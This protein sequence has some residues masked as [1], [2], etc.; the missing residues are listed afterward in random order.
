MDV[1]HIVLTHMDF[2]HSGGLS[3]FPDAIVHTT[4]DEYAAAVTDPD[5]L[6]RRRYRPRQWAHGPDIRIHEG[7]GDDWKLCRRHVA[8]GATT[9]EGRRYARHG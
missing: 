1:T 2:E 7:R 3:E 5:F 8:F 4:A 6:D 9:N